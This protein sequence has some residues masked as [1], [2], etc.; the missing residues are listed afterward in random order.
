[1][2][3]KS[4]WTPEEVDLILNSMAETTRLR[5]DD[6]DALLEQAH[7]HKVRDQLLERQW[8]RRLAWAST[9]LLEN[10][11][12]GSARFCLAD[13]VWIGLH[14]TIADMWD[15]YKKRSKY[16]ASGEKPRDELEQVRQEAFTAFW[17]QLDSFRS[18]FTEDERAA[19]S[20]MR[21]VRCHPYQEVWVPEIK[22][23]QIVDRVKSRALDTRPRTKE[24]WAAFDAFLAKYGGGDEEKT[25]INIAVRIWKPAAELLAALDA[26]HLANWRVAERDKRV[27]DARTSIP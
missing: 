18:S 17:R 19:I 24:A 25:V 3:W 10:V 11:T 6:I 26:F 7:P 9:E 21:Q 20:L 23:K 16:E 13:P 4:V 14:G 22:N 12:I 1:M 27:R 15:R 8:I 2:G 5:R